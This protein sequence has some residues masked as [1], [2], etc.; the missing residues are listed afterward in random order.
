MAIQGAQWA[1]ENKDKYGI[2]IVTSSLG[3]QRVEVHWI[4]TA[5]QPGAG[6]WILLSRQE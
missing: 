5:T 2:D 4:T 3:E 1:I 6:R